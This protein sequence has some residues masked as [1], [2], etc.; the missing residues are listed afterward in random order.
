MN[1]NLG[2]LIGLLVFLGVLFWPE[3]RSDQ[4][5]I[6]ESLYNIV[7]GVADQE[8]RTV[9]NEISENYSDE[10]GWKRKNI[11]GVLFQQFQ[12]RASFSL[13]IT[14]QRF[15]ITPPVAK[16]DA[17]VVLIGGSMWNPNSDTMTFDVQ[18]SYKKE[19][20]GVWRMTSHTRKEQ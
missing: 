3:A 14:A 6:Q 18:F 1:R 15:M 5:Q 7:R 16:I 11:R 4:E 2:L 19:D 12:Q 8:N 9:L 20:D 17:E 13:Q 10:T